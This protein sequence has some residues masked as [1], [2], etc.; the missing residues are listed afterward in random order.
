MP[1]FSCSRV[2]PCRQAFE[3]ALAHLDCVLKG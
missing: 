2:P 1:V 3:A